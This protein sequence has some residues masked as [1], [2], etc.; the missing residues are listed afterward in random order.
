MNLANN[1]MQTIVDTAQQFSKSTQT[2][3][4]TGEVTSVEPLKIKIQDGLIIDENFLYMSTLVRETWINIPTHGDA[5]HDHGEDEALTFSI[6]GACST[7]PIN[8]TVTPTGSEPPPAP[9]PSINFS[10]K[11]KIHKALPKILLWRGL[12][13][14][15]T[16]ILL[17]MPPNRF[18]VLERVEGTTNDPDE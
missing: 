16:V 11:H 2:S 14:G 3:T 9:G 1:I 18:Y 10:H 15:D 8:F 13:V 5:E 7:G 17:K 6:S 12:R 4:C